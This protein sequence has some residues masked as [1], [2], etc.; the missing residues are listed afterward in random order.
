MIE[1]IQTI[2][3]FCGMYL[4]IR[5]IRTTGR[6]APN[7]KDRRLMHAHRL[8]LELEATDK[9]MNILPLDLKNELQQYMD[10][11]RN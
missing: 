9:V 11:A 4:I 8:L 3:G 1:I 7:Y 2:I 5:L 10:K 6:Y